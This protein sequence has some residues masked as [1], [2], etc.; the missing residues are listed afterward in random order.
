[1]KNTGT[2]FM[3][4]TILVSTILLF[5]LTSCSKES[6]TVKAEPVSLNPEKSQYAPYEIVTITSSENLFT[7]KSFTAKI[8]DIAVTI[9]SNENTASFVLPN[10]SNGNYDLSFTLNEKNYIVLITVASLS[11]VLSANE[12]F[13][14][15]KTSINQNIT[16]L[17]L[18][19]TLLE[20]N[21]TS[22]NEYA[23]LKND[24]I[25]YTN[26]LN[27]YT[28]SYNNLSVI[29]KQEF[30]KT[31]AANKA[32]ID[33]YNQLIK[34]LNSSTTSLKTAQSVQD[35]EA[36]V[37]ISMAAYI[38]NIIKTAA[39]VGAMSYTGS[40][41]AT[42]NPWVSAGAVIATGFLFVEYCILL[43]KTCTASVTLTNKAIKPFELIAQ[44]S[45]NVFISDI[46]TD[47]NNQAKYR[48]LIESDSNDSN[49]GSTI[50]TI[51]EKYN[52]IKKLIND[53]FNGLPSIL[54]PSWRMP[55]LKNTY[56]STTRSIFNKYISITNVNNP[57]VTLQQLNQADG[58]IKIKAT[59]TE[60]TDQIFTY[61]VNYMNSNF[62]NGLKKTVNAKVLAVN[63]NTSTL[64]V[65]ATTVA[66]NATATATGGQ[67]PYTYA[68]SN[69]AIGV[70]AT[71]LTDGGK[72]TVTVTDAL[73]CT[74]KSNEVI[75]N[76]CSSQ[77][78]A[79]SITSDGVVLCPLGLSG[80][81]GCMPEFEIQFSYT[82]QS[83]GFPFGGS[84]FGSYSASN[85]P[86]N[87]EW[88]DTNGV[89]QGNASNSYKVYKVNG[90]QNSG[91]VKIKF[92]N[93]GCA[94]TRVFCESTPPYERLVTKNWKYSV[95]D[96][97]GLVSNIIYFTTRHYEYGK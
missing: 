86:V 37:Q 33:E 94:A 40:F 77:N 32:L 96:K 11:T 81:G 89:W 21:S 43:D 4:C 91:T 51:T 48:S 55:S 10:L 3:Y 62:T 25:K 2:L 83:V 78:K 57:K 54:R 9:G 71:S 76:V 66:D 73:G 34:D 53:A 88:Q 56:N 67:A 49:N 87:L 18:Q 8:N 75:V 42:P 20:Q 7:I 52:S 14:E 17:N 63:C 46:A 59:T 5:S 85:Y 12:Y 47:S 60:T 82:A 95:T 44:T 1:M 26:L 72:Y 22:P 23:T 6:E 74:K 84:Y 93:S 68:W 36:R 13:D 19:I 30:A 64:A 50:N 61:D 45:Q 35:Y 58:S 29:E 15:I 38:K 80:G 16:D 28:N 65:T 31:M 27:D 79:I 41:I 97:C 39:L 69:G 70:S 90:D 92:I 24:L